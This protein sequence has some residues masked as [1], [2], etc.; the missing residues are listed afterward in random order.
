MRTSKAV[1]LLILGL[2]IAAWGRGVAARQVG[3]DSTSDAEQLAALMDEGQM[4]Y[5][6]DCAACHVE[7]TDS[8]GP[9]MDGNASLAE[10]DHV[11]RRILEGVPAKGMPPFATT[12]TDRK[13]AAVSTFIRNA[14][15]N[16]Y[17]IVLEADV[18][19]VR[20]ELKNKK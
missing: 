12:L 20:E 3:Q 17:G 13:I 10:K 5:G 14:W 15:D 19:R 2:S 11:I 7:G 18:K 1:V 16:A 6:S 9:M 8:V 4:I